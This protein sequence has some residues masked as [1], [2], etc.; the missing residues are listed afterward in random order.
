MTG[1]KRDEVEQRYG[2]VDSA[3]GVESR[4]AGAARARRALSELVADPSL[5]Q[6]GR[7]TA[8]WNQLGLV[9]GTWRVDAYDQKADADQPD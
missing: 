2:S 8:C 5:E 7:R 6:I 1:H 4:T 9:G 3:P